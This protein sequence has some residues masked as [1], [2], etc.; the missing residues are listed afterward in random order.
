VT[1]DQRRIRTG[2]PRAGVGV[3]DTTF[4]G[5]SIFRWRA[6]NSSNQLK[7][8]ALSSGERFAQSIF[9]SSASI[10]GVEV[11]LRIG[12]ALGVRG[13]GDVTGGRGGGEVTGVRGGGE[14]IG[15]RG[16]GEVTGVREGGDVAGVRGGKFT[17]G[18]GGVGA[19]EF[20]LGRELR[21]IGGGLMLVGDSVCEFVVL[22]EPCRI[23][24]GGYA[25]R[26][27]LALFPEPV[28]LGGSCGGGELKSNLVFLEGTDLYLSFVLLKPVTVASLALPA[29]SLSSATIAMVSS[30]G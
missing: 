27:P 2:G 7:N 26:A 12:G 15:V 9:S 30:A 20:R 11:P 10:F 18:G 23:G 13:G 28:A 3:S 21:D 19:L 29:F 22:V 1:Y 5:S 24:G 6:K 4:G 17:G 25:F 8:T 16:G 14:T